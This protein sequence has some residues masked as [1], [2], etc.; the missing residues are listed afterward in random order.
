MKVVLVGAAA[1]CLVS[2]G[3]VTALDAAAAPR[4]GEAFLGYTLRAQAVGMQVTED[5]PTATTHPEAEG[6]VPLSQVSLVSGPVGYA[7]S[8]IAWP[9]P[10]A[11]NAGS[12][13]VLA[14]APVPEETAQQLNYPVRAETRTGG[15]ASVTNDSVPGAVMRAGATTG[16]VEAESVLDGADAGQ[17][18]GLGRTTTATSATL[19]ATTATSQARTT[20]QDVSLAGGALTFRSLTSEATATT[21][22]TTAGGKGRTVVTDLAIGGVPVTVDNRGVTVDGSSTPVDPTARATVDQVLT[23]LGMT[24]VLSEPSN[25]KQ[26]GTISYDAG[27]LVVVWRPQGS[28]SVI[29]ASFGGARVAAAA[30]LA[31]PLVGGGTLAPPLTPGAGVPAAG[32]A[33][34]VVPTGGGPAPVTGEVPGGTPPRVAGEQSPVAQAEALLSGTGAPASAVALAVLGA[35]LLLAGLL[36]LPGS[37][38][39]PAPSSTCT[40]RRSS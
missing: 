21:D 9:G 18:V 30:S 2:A 11:G 39:V 25:A 22:G 1:L 19:A 14:G 35:L 7:L 20:T 8:S 5:Q 13:L 15:P 4:P 17:T 36:R 29:S 31:D 6:E 16:R 24:V 40:P 33:V 37:V 34:G 27:S 12:L 38:F 3:V 28:A 26:G 10:L 23:A 32:G